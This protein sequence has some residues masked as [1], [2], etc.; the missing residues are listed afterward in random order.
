MSFGIRGH[1]NQLKMLWFEFWFGSGWFQIARPVLGR[2]LTWVLGRIFH[3]SSWKEFH[4][5]SWK[6]FHLGSQN[7]SH[8]GSWK[9]SHLGPWKDAYSCYQKDAHLGSGG[10]FSCVLDL[11]Q[12][13]GRISLCFLEGSFIWVL[14]RMFTW[15]FWRILNTYCSCSR[16]G[17]T[18]CSLL[19]VM[20]GVVHANVGQILLFCCNIKSSLGDW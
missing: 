3:S 20:Y 4:S 9:D 10:G 7:E 12:V 16:F 19:L 17:S 13:L 14:R 11:P 5:G 18:W 1:C 2:I 15:I 6:Y 8:W